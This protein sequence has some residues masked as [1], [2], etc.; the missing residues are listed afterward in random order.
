MD[1]RYKPAIRLISLVS[2]F[3]FCWSFAGGVD[4][5]YAIKTSDKIQVASSKSDNQRLFASN[6]QSNTPKPAETF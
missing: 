6:Q 1:F 2:L 4:I 5:A 3:F